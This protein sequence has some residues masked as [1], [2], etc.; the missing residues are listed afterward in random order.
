MDFKTCP[1]MIIN[2]FLDKEFFSR[3]KK[4]KKKLRAMASRKSG[5]RKTW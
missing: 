4:I 1:F 2:H 3:E 5:Y